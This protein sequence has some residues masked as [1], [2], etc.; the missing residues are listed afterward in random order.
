MPPESR[1]YLDGEPQKVARARGDRF[2]ERGNGALKS[3]SIKGRL[4]GRTIIHPY[5]GPIEFEPE[6]ASTAPTHDVRKIT[7]PTYGPI[8]DRLVL[9]LMSR[10]VSVLTAIGSAYFVMSS[11]HTEEDIDKAME[12]FGASLDAMLAEGSIPNALLGG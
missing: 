7:D 9:H 5:F 1:L 11:A 10:G 3:R 2:R 4:Y 6:D 12:A 8:R